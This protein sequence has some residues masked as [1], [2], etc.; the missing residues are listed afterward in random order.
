VTD[1]QAQ[2][3]AARGC[4]ATG[5]L[6]ALIV[7]TALARVL[8]DASVGLSVDESY[9]LAIARRF[10][11]S[12]FDHPPLHLWL[13]GAWRE[14]LGSED[15]RVIRL[16]FVAL[17]AGSTW[18]AFWV[19]A[20]VFGAAAGWWSVVALNLAPL[21]TVGIAS[22]I[23]P[24]GPLVF[25]SLLCVALF[26]QVRTRSDDALALWAGV[27]L[28]GGLALLSKYLAVFPLAGLVIYLV[29]SPDRRWLTRPGPW[30]AVAVCALVCSPVLLWNA[31]HDWVSF[32]FQGRR[33]LPSG[34][35]LSRFGLDVAAQFAVLLPWVALGALVALLAVLRRGPLA[36]GWLFA[37]L[38]LPCIAS[39]GLAPLWT[40][41]L[42]HWPAIGWLFAFA[43]L[44]ARLAGVSPRYARQLRACAAASAILV[45]LLV[46]LFVAQTRTGLLERWAPGLRAHD[47]TLEFL[48]WRALRTH[49]AAAGLLR[50]G[51][52]IATVSWI[53][54]GKVDVALAGDTP[55]LCLSVD[56]R[57]FAALHAAEAF[58]GRDALLLADARRTDWLRIAGARFGRVEPLPALVLKR[59]ARAALTLNLARASSFRPQ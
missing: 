9:T 4:S 42:P 45:V 24:D 12:Y 41:I 27:G 13:L 11:L 34:F 26:L 16:P 37:C 30:L 19:T 2:R 58:Y 25:C 53:D 31:Q 7:L 20:R 43:L 47:P 8:L 44:G 5:P 17:F 23:L 56:P 51:M 54:A 38:A 22:W 1:G 28:A 40:M 32:A 15:P 57:G 21:F 49:V 35:S 59:G 48:D 29:S 18:L 36:P 33:A 52:F 55:V 6:L 39:F 10:A 3:P 46:A 14:L 50:P